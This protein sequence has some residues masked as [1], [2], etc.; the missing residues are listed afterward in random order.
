MKYSPTVPNNV[1]EV[2]G[3]AFDGWC[4]IYSA[5]QHGYPPHLLT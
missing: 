5:K 1:Y 4:V 2:Q 3:G